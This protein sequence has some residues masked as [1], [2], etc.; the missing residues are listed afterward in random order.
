MTASFGYSARLWRFD[1]QR[2]LR[3]LDGPVWAVAVTPDGRFALA[4]GVGERVRVWHLESGDP[5]NVTNEDNASKR[6]APWQN[7]DH[8]GARLFRKCANFH[9]LTVNERQPAGP[10][11]AGLVRRRAGG[12]AG[13]RYSK[14]LQDADVAWSCRTIT[15]LFRQGPDRHLSGTKMP[16]RKVGNE[17]S[18][19]QLIDFMEQVAP[20]K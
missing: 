20:A 8:P 15:K 1:E 19:R 13:Y 3:V 11:F 5:I 9:A 7:S 14:A 6:I 18:L 4:A 2:E 17:T 10:H 12:L 16:V